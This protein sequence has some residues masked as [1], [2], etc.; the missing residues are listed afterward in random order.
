MVGLGLIEFAIQS[1]LLP[2]EQ[3]QPA[4]CPECAAKSNKILSELTDQLSPEVEDAWKKLEAG[5][6]KSKQFVEIL[7]KYYDNDKIEEL[8]N[9]LLESS[10]PKGCPDVEFDGATVPKCNVDAGVGF[11]MGIC[12]YLDGVDCQDLL[13]RYEKGVL[14]AEKLLA[15]VKEHTTDKETLY[16][17][18][19]I[20]KTIKGF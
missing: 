1:R 2:P 5:E 14:T 11:I 12:Q 7:H 19:T 4:P 18:E 8:V 6:I 10:D 3:E 16:N 13:T 15:T 20:R 17:L 9:K